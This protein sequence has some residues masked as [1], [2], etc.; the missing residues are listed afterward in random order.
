MTRMRMRPPRTG[1][2]I[3]QWLTHVMNAEGPRWPLR[4]AVE[5]VFLLPLS[6]TDRHRRISGQLSDHVSG[7]YGSSDDDPGVQAA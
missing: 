4:S 6:I 2:G 5:G 1:E 7:T 3:P